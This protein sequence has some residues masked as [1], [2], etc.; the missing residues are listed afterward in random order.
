MTFLCRCLR[1]SPS[2]ILPKCFLISWKTASKKKGLKQETW[3]ESV[4]QCLQ[5]IQIQ[6]QP[7][8]S[9]MYNRKQY[10]SASLPLCGNWRMQDCHR[11]R[12]LQVS[13]IY[14][15]LHAG[16]LVWLLKRHMARRA[17]KSKNSQTQEF[18]SR[19]VSVFSLRCLSKSC[20]CNSLRSYQKKFQIQVSGEK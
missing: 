20:Y 17:N 7:V 3:G 16:F 6:L 12:L 2:P 10:S 11:C 4:V 13:V 18:P 5:L 14:F 1:F 15:L 9:E 19:N 8:T